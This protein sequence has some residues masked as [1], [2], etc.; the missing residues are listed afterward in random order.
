MKNID[1][2]YY[3][4]C[5]GKHS[6]I[7][8]QI[9]IPLE[10]NMTVYIEEEEYR[11]TPQELC[12][13]PEGM[14]HQ[15]DFYGKMIVLNLP[16]D[17]N[18]QE[19]IFLTSPMIVSMIG[20]ILQLVELIQA[21]LRQNP[22]GKAV[23]FLYHFL[24]SKLMEQY[25]PPSIRYMREHYDM[26][27]TVEQLADMENY[28]VNYY[29]DWFKQQTGISP[30]LYLRKIRIEKAKKL[31]ED[32]SYGVTDIAIMVGYSSNSTFTRAFHG[33]TGMTPKE[34]RR[35]AAEGFR[36]VMNG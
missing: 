34:Y 21:E 3:K 19:G 14:A 33:A 23:E 22:K 2:Q 6:H 25:A 9:L 1:I 12:L 16:E 10:K 20:Q 27:I 13:V 35:Y 18:D 28:N 32:T 15:C 26:P 30:G 7:Y 11:V 17:I 31:L 36:L 29:N 8:A 24:Y 5:L 4:E